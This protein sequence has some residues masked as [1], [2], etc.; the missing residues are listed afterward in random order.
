VHGPRDRGRHE[1]ATPFLATEY[2]DG[3]SLAE[4][5]SVNGSLG[6]DMLVGLAAGLAEALTAIHAAGVVHRDLKPGNVLLTSTG[7]KVI[8]FGIAQALD[9][10]S[11][12]K[13]GMTAGSPGFMAPEQ[14]LGQGD[15]PQMSSPGA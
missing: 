1:S 3:P 9:S 15:S 11:L 12:T 6:P 4:Y 2:V 7:P 5:V 14:I 8:D 13:T 10:T